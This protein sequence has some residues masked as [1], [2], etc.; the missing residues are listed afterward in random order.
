MANTNCEVEKTVAMLEK[1]KSAECKKK[2][3]P[4]NSWADL[5]VTVEDAIIETKNLKK[6]LDE[7]VT[8]KSPP[9]VASKDT[10]KKEKEQE[11]EQDEQEPK[12]KN[13]M[14]DGK[15]QRNLDVMN[16]EPCIYHARGFC[17]YGQACF[18]LHENADKTSEDNAMIT[19]PAPMMQPLVANNGQ[20]ICRYFNTRNGCNR[21]DNCAFAH[22]SNTKPIRRALGDRWQRKEQ[23]SQQQQSQPIK[24]LHKCPNADC[25]NM[26]FG[27]QC[28]QC[29]EAM[30]SKIK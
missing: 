17:R 13:E 1:E 28:S 19:M 23:Q 4:K 25:S 12:E 11:Q 15:K 18:Y 9:Y 30:F 5:S 26:C 22:V 16:K 29:H 6:P 27:K 20:E 8:P 21:K 2:E 14:K 10:Q 3:K 7:S 24:I